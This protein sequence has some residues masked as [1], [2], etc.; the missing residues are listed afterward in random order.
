MRILV[1]GAS[2]YVGWAVA[3]EL[4]ARGH[5][6]VALVH[7]QVPSFPADVAVRIGD[8]LSEASL[9]DAVADVDAV[10]HLAARTRVREAATQPTRVW[11]VNVTGTLNVLDAL[12]VQAARTGEPARLVF[13]STGTVYGTPAEQPISERTPLAPMNPYGASKAAAEQIVG[14]QAATGSLGAV[15]L[16]VFNAAGAVAGRADSDLTRIIPKAAAVAAGQEST[17]VVNGDGTAVR[18]FVHVADIARAVALALEAVQPGEHRTYNLGAVPA[19]VAEIIKA[20]ERVSGHPVAIE[21]RTAYAG[22]APELRADTTKIRAE[23]GW[24]P[25]R[26]TLDEL[27]RDQW[28]AIK[29]A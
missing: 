15:V 10:C 19:S 14:W 6:V 5:Q 22:E 2:G 27:V 20:V 12:A 7:E 16:R 25:E 23:L 3:H 11:R 4:R 28:T 18:D 26:T 1:T 17:V 9:R 29:P 8:V 13:A 21:H 24:V